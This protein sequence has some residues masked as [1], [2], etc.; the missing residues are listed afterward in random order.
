MAVAEVV[1]VAAGGE[2]IARFDYECAGDLMRDQRQTEH[3]QGHRCQDQIR[4][5]HSPGD[6][7]IHVTCMA[8]VGC[9]EFLSL[10][11]NLLML[12]VY[13]SVINHYHMVT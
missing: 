8:G 12:L 7:L 6:L 4:G 9:S 13:F 5:W 10:S 11:L 3:S 2:L 1:A